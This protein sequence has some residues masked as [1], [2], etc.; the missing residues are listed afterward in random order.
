MR[1]PSARSGSFLSP[2]ITRISAT[3][4]IGF[5]SLLAIPRFRGSALRRGTVGI[6][7][8]AQ[9]ERRESALLVRFKLTF[10]DQ[11]ERRGKA[12][13]EHSRSH[14]RFHQISQQ[15]LIERAPVH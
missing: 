14:C 10:T 3:F 12:R 6:P 11:F 13:G 5:F 4:P 9:I 15:I 8:L 7:S 2:T 1:S